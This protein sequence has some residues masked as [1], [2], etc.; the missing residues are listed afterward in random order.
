MPKTGSLPAPRRI[1]M[2]PEAIDQ[3]LRDLSQLH[4]LGLSLRDVQLVG[5]A[6]D[7]RRNT[8]GG[9]RGDEGPWN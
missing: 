3:R 6:A 9:Q 4:K 7:L 5:R 1:D 2:S 8:N